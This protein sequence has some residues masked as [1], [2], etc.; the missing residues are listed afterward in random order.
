MCVCVYICFIR[1]SADRVILCGLIF[2]SY[3]KEFYKNSGEFECV[4][5]IKFSSQMLLTFEIKKI[6]NYS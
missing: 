2:N 4:N 6:L 1:M 5:K 3:S